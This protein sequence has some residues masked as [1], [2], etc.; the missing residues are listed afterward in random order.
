[1]P[2]SQEKASQLIICNDS[3]KLQGFSVVTAKTYTLNL[4][5]MSLFLPLILI[6]CR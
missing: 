6:D 3:S 4:I 1:M 5:K 2:T